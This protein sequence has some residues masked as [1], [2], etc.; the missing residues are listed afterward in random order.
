MIKCGL[1]AVAFGANPSSLKKG[2][3]KTVKELVMVLRE[4]SFPVKGRDDIRGR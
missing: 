3:D 4:N 1:L 2:M